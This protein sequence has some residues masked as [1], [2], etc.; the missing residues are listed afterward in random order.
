MS[1]RM[2]EVLTRIAVAMERMADVQEAGHKLNRENDERRVYEYERSMALNEVMTESN[3]NYRLLKLVRDA[4]GYHMERMSEDHIED[5]A[6]GQGTDLA[7]WE[8]TRDAAMRAYY[9]RRADADRE[10]R[11]AEKVKAND[12]A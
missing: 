12:E 5:M 1:D 8:D 9:R 6:N 3:L 10:A 7:L 11:E 4:D 2:I